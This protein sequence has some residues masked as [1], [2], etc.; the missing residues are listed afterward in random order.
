M[1][2]VPRLRHRGGGLRDGAG[3]W[4]CGRIRA[5]S[6]IVGAVSLRGSAVPREPTGG[7]SERAFWAGPT[8]RLWGPG[9]PSRGAGRAISVTPAP[10]RGRGSS[11]PAPGALPFPESYPTRET[12]RFRKSRKRNCKQVFRSLGT[13]SQASRRRLRTPDTSAVKN[14]GPCERRSSP[15]ASPGHLHRPF[16]CKGPQTRRRSAPSPRPRSRRWSASSCSASV[17]AS[18][19]SFPQERETWALQEYCGM[20]FVI[21]CLFASTAR[22]GVK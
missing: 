18:S 8:A 13:V 14:E 21:G 17:P 22:R 12:Q 2:R 19:Q 4:R 6:A 15:S 10:K 20:F 5:G 9:K 16:T 7:G 3:P 11:R 1:P